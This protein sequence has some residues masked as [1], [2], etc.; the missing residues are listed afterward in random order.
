TTEGEREYLEFGEFR[1]EVDGEA[2]TLQAY[3]RDPDETSLWVP[4]RDAT[5][6]EETYGAGRYLD[7]DGDDDR[8]D[9]G[10]WVLD[11]NYAYNPFCVYSDQ[12]ECPLVPAENW[13]EVPIRA[14]EL[15]FEH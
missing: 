13:L 15:A 9:S 3:R 7:L 14:G 5:S 10:A 6:G 8:T 2:A 1:F 4:F 12:Y 11:F